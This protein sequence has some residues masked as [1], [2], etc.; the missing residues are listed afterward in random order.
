MAVS[1]H[2]LDVYRDALSSEEP[3]W[4]LRDK[5]VAELA[6]NGDDRERVVAD[7]EKLRAVLRDEGRDD[8]DELVLD[9]IGMVVGW[10]GPRV[11]I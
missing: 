8:D 9:V 5:V 4:T 10:S 11:R 2:I 1:H 7:L 6:E 3:L